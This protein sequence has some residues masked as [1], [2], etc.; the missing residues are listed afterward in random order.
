M[1]QADR[2]KGSKPVVDSRSGK[3]PHLGAEPSK[4]TH[5]ES[6]RFPLDRADSQGEDGRPFWGDC[7]EKVRRTINGERLIRAIA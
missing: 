4:A 7:V 3:R 1:T 5:I 2:P 6:A